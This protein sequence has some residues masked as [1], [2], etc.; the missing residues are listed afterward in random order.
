[1][2][3][4]LIH[5]IL[6]TTNTTNF[7][8]NRSQGH[9]C[10]IWKHLVK[11]FKIFCTLYQM[12]KTNLKIIAHSYKPGRDPHKVHPQFEDNLA[13]GWE[14]QKCKCGQAVLPCKSGRLLMILLHSGLDREDGK[15]S[16]TVPCTH[17]SDKQTRQVK[18]S[19][20]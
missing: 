3:S 12:K 15:Q 4:S 6:N 16:R 9:F 19:H 2:S 14:K 8:N 7:I 1:M 5:R 17:P 18:G 13:S 11:Q 10:V 20:P